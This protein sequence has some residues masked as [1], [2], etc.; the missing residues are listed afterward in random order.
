MLEEMGECPALKLQGDSSA[1][2]GTLQREGAGKVKHLEVRQLWMQEKI[3]SGKLVFEKIDR[4]MNTADTLTKHWGPAAH[5][6][7]QDARFFPT[8]HSELEK[9]APFCRPPPREVRRQPHDYAALLSSLRANY[10]APPSTTP[11]LTFGAS[12]AGSYAA[13]MRLRFPALVQRYAVVKGP[14]MNTRKLLCRLVP[15]QRGFGA[16]CAAQRSAALP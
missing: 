1:S 3:K 4:V 6:L 15:R 14:A 13:M 12:L 7:F 5:K 16:A 11:L 10:S 8:P 2:K 9:P